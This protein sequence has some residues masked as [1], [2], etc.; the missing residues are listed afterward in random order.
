[1][2]KHRISMVSTID[3][4][5]HVE[6]FTLMIDTQLAGKSIYGDLNQSKIFDDE[7]NLLLALDIRF[8]EPSEMHS[9]KDWL[10]DQFGS[11]PVFGKWFKSA[12]INWHR[13][14]HDDL[15]VENCSLTEYSEW[16]K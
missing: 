10:I 8:N 5:E 14:T 3:S 12:N 13:C 15:L 7:G 4:E 16:N 11:H 2:S 9:L 6:T 1:M